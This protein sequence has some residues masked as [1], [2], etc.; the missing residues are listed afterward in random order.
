[1]TDEQAG[2][3]TKKGTDIPLE[4]VQVK[5]QITGRTARVKIAQRFRNHESSPVEAV[6][7]FPL[8]ETCAL[9]GFRAVAGDRTFSGAIEERELAFRRY[10]EA[11]IDG[12]G[13][14]LLDQERPNIFTLSIGNLD[15]G[16][17]AVIELEYIEMLDTN[18]DEVR[19]VLPTTIAPRYVPPSSPAVDGIPAGHL[20]NPGFATSVPY[21]ISIEMLIC[22]KDRVS[23]VE[24]PS[25]RTTTAF[26]GNDIMLSL[27][28]GTAKMDRDFILTV[29]YLSLIHI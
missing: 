10:D 26:T 4:G 1:M 29:K 25:H 27:A 16:T 20:V 12:D 24:C 18:E 13:A 7:K 21:G 17:T 28:G 23:S 22:G 2:L 11:I 8:P 5:G 15:P 3:L 14:Y 6:Y 19:L 9:C